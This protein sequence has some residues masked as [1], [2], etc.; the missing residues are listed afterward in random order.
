MIT[1]VSVT[2]TQ[3]TTIF[4][5]FCVPFMTVVVHINF[6]AN[7]IVLTKLVWDCSYL[8]YY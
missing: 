7:F 4:L 6:I 8:M 1:G 3:N 5:L 2:L